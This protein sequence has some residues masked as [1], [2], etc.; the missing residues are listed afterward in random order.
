MKV[1]ALGDQLVRDVVGQVSV[2]RPAPGETTA[3]ALADYRSRGD[4]LYAE[5]N[6]RLHL[7]DINPDDTVLRLAVGAEHDRRARRLGGVPRD[8]RALSVRGGRD[9]R[10]RR[11][12][13]QPR[14]PGPDLRLE[15]NVS[16]SQLHDRYP[17][18]QR[19]SRHAR[20]RYRRGC[21]RQRHRDRRPGLRLAPDRRA[22]VRQ[23]RIGRGDLRRGKRHRL[24]CEPRRDVDQSQPRR[25]QPGRD[26]D[27]ALQRGRARNQLLPLRRRRRRGKRRA[28]PHRHIQ[29]PV[30]G[31]S[32][33]LPP[34]KAMR[35][36]TSRTTEAPTCSSPRRA[37]TSFRRTRGHS[38]ARRIQSD[39]ARRAEPRW[40]RLWSPLLQR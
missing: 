26:A 12:R 30:P 29:Q 7:L 6:L 35:R 20:V 4:V 25:L 23:Q 17:D 8:V 34:T 22:C 18:R 13:D 39:I 31:R 2:V 33:L 9:R 15:R 19:G 24:G 21:D 16:R 1:A 32:A 38:T 36:R 40:L 3:E 37:S 28:R 5:P 14:S 11:G 27:H 10:Q